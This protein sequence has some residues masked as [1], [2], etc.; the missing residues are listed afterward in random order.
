MLSRTFGV[1][2]VLLALAVLNGGFREMVLTPRLGEYPAHTISC[3]LLSTAIA[4]VAW[5]SIGWIG[6]ATIVESL[7]IGATWLA[8]TVAFEFLVGHYVFGSS[9]STLLADYQIHRGR[10]W[11]LVL[12][13]SFFA[14]PWAFSQHLAP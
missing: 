14:P 8:A 13:A 3:I 7:M 5:M 10:L 6:P 12:V 1:W 9:W 2:L 11:A 4:T